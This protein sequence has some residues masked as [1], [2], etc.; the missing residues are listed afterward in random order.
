MKID[1]VDSKLSISGS[2]DNYDLLVKH[3]IHSVINLKGESHD[4]I[5]ELTKRRIAYYWIPIPDWQAPR[6]AQ[7]KLFNELMN[8]IKG[9]VLV[10]C[11]VG[12]G[13]SVCLCISYLIENKI[14]DTIKDGIEYMNKIRSISKMW[15]TQLNKLGEL[16]E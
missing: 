2:I 5:N 8:N 7:I 4:D 6:S 16:Y 1:D 12:M 3:K 14:V 15:N 9:R 11:E 13:R 10:H